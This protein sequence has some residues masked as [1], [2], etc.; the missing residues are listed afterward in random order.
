MVDG[1]ASVFERELLLAVLVGWSEVPAGGVRRLVGLAA[2]AGRLGELVAAPGLLSGVE[3]AVLL[4]ALHSA[5]EQGRVWAAVLSAAGLP[6]AWVTVAGQGD[7]LRM[8]MSGFAAVGAGGRVAGWGGGSVVEPVWSTAPPALGTPLTGTSQVRAVAAVP[9]PDGSTLLA[10]G[11]D[12]GTVRLWD[13]ITGEP[14]GAPL[15]VHTD[16]VR[17][18][19]AVLLP[20]GRTLLASGGND[21]TVRLWDPIT[22]EPVGKP[23]TGH[24]NGVQAL[25][26]VPLPGGSTLLAS[27]NFNGT[28][29]LWDPTTGEP[30]G[31]PLTGHTRWVQAVAAVPLPD[32]RTLLASGSFDGTVRLWDPTT[33]ERVGHFETP[34]MVHA[35]SLLPDGQLA[36]GYGNH[37]AVTRLNA[38]LPKRHATSRSAGAER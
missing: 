8:A 15:T 29:R 6:A 14:A 10:S 7:R 17:A 21:G 36:V 30:V 31:K 37:V 38:D 5:G 18:V 25:T 2:A 27:G 24:T 13:P 9:L 4:F 33:G 22:G 23:L 35:I 32:G 11:S 26:A 1:A 16:E 3:P 28:V 12:N 19:A 20:G 34:E